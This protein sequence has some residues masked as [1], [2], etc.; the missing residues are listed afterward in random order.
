MELFHE[1]VPPTHLP[2]YLRAN[3]QSEFFTLK[4]LEKNAPSE[5]RKVGTPN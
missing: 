5:L 3:R 4:E 2:S 1:K